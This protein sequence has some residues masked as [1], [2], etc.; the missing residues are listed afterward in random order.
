MALLLLPYPVAL[1]LQTTF[2]LYCK[3]VWPRNPSAAAGFL[4]SSERGKRIQRTHTLP[5]AP[6]AGPR[7]RRTRPAPGR[8]AGMRAP[9]EVPQSRRGRKGRA[10]RRPR[11]PPQ[12]RLPPGPA[13]APQPRPR[14]G[15]RA[16]AARAPRPPGPRAAAGAESATYFPPAASA[17][18]R[19]PS[20]ATAEATEAAEAGPAPLPTAAAPRRAPRSP[21]PQPAGKRPSA[22]AAAPTTPSRPPKPRT[23]R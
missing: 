7:G 14:R 15:V 13:A 17:P 3:A 4:Q 6:G 16:A 23:Q 10:S 2:L 9:S 22:A 1:S 8:G 18:A 11:T 12:W 20:P 19:A 5:S 21:L